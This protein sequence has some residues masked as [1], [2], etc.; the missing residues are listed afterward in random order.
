MK[1]V[2]AMIMAVSVFAGSVNYT[3]FAEESKNADEQSEVFQKL[4]NT[5]L[6]EEQVENNLYLKERIEDLKQFLKTYQ[7]EENDFKKYKLLEDKY[8]SV[9]KE[10]R[11]YNNSFKIE[12]EINV[13]KLCEIN[14]K[15]K[16]LYFESDCLQ[17]LLN[18]S[19]RPLKQQLID[20]GKIF[21]GVSAL[22]TCDLIIHKDFSNIIGY[23]PIPL[24]CAIY[25][26]FL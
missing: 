13:Q 2:I 15:V 11:N 14:S 4:I 22:L 17:I 12:E 21:L 3:S 20:A 9:F 5:N 16:A 7:K 25:S 1:K 24:G 6:K 19:K 18:A 23:F 26:F 10:I 8:S